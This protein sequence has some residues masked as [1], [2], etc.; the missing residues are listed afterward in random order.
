[1]KRYILCLLTAVIGLSA[2]SRSPSKSLC[3][4]PAYPLAVGDSKSSDITYS[5]NGLYMYDIIQDSLPHYEIG[6]IDIQ[7]VRYMEEGSGFYVKADS[8]HAHNVQFSYEVEDAPKGPIEFNETTGRFKY[9]P[10]AEDYNS[11]FVTFHA[12]NGVDN[13]S[14]RVRFNLMPQTIAEEFAFRTEGTMPDGQD[15]TLIAEDSTSTAILLNNTTRKGRK[16]S[17]SGKEVVFDDKVENKVFGLSG[18][19]DIC[20]LNIFA[21]RLVVRSAL[22]F[23]QTNVTIYAKELV[24]EDKGDA[25]ASINTSPL[26]LE[27]L[28]NGQGQDG[29]NAGN[30]TL[31]V[32]DFKANPA[33][34]FIMN[35][36]KG[37]SANRNGTPANGGN[38]GTLTSNIDL[39]NYCDFVRGSGGVRFDVAD[40][41]STA[42]GAVIAA[43]AMG[44]DGH[45]ELVD[46]PYAYLHPYYISAVI[47]QV[48]DAFVNNY[49]Q[50][51]LQTCSEYKALIDEYMSSEAW[52]QCEAE[53]EVELKNDLTEIEGLLFKLDQGLDYFGNPIGWTPLLS[54]EVMLTNFDNE[55]ERA[56]PTLYMY[57]WLSRVDQTL[58][59]KVLANQQFA[60]IAEQEIQS[61]QEFINN[62]VLKI[63]VI[64]DELKEVESM[65]EIVNQKIGEIENHL[66][67]KARHN[68][69][70]KNRIKK[71]ASICKSIASAVS[72]CG[73]WGAAIGTALNV[74]SN[75]AF[76]SGKL[77]EYT[78]LDTS[79][80]NDLYNEASNIFGNAG[81]VSIDSLKKIITDIPWKDIGDDPNMLKTQFDRFSNAAGPLISNITSLSGTLSKSSTPDDEVQRE[82]KRL[83]SESTEWNALNTEMDKLNAK[84][85]K[86][87]SD[88]VLTFKDI[89]TTLS[90]VGGDIISLDVFRRKVFD[91]NSKRDLNAMQYLERMEQK[92]KFR[93]LKYHY[94]LRKAYEY[95]L[96][97]PYQGE[98][99]LVGMFER[100][101]RLGSTFGDIVNPDAYSTLAS[102][103]K[104]VISEM[105]EEIIN[106]YSVNY[107]EQSAP[108]TIVIP[109]EQLNV[110]NDGENLVLNLHDM[111]VFAPDEENVRIVDLAIQHI[112]THIDGNVGYSGY[113]DLNMTHEGISKFR[114]DGR[115]YWFDHR[116]QSTTSPHT[117]GV[118]YDAV[119][120]ESTMIQPSAATSSLLAAILKTNTANNLM[121]FS[122]PSAW[123]DI[124]M[125]KKV[126]TS[127]G[128]DVVVDSLVLRLQY[129][130]TRRPNNLRNIDIATSNQLMPHI[131]CSET[132]IN[133]R[134]NGNGSFY[135]SYNLS[136][137]PITF[138]AIE[139][140]GTYC[141]ANWTDRSGKIVSDEPT[142]TVSREIDQ[143]YTANYVR[144]LPIL[145]VPDTIWVGHD[146]GTQVVDVRN[147]GKGNIE[148]EWYVSDEK[149]SW[150]HLE[151]GA[152]GI[153][154]GIFSFKY[155]L[156]ENRIQRKD[157]IVIYA[158]ETEIGSKTIYISQVDDPTIGIS[159]IVATDGE[160]VIS[161]NPTSNN[162]TVRGEALVSVEI[163][164]AT[165]Q[166]IASYSANGRTH[167]T[168]NIGQY[169][170]GVYVFAV[171]SKNGM[172][173]KKVLKN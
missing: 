4:R 106:D 137:Q 72:V 159:P 88:L 52:S 14:E 78:G 169:P 30:I 104:D 148:M 167:I 5:S 131:S 84:K 154:N 157:S 111:G 40:D 93:L 140:Y 153:D 38:G 112:E 81:T 89:N 155:E 41:G 42:A 3:L 69:K 59:N 11:F 142:L 90:D 100:F 56:I 24:F 12:T 43:G 114:K 80:I 138:T 120:K 33:K 132:D 71:A 101:E 58:Q 21:E 26:P 13:L 55:V 50:Y 6:H 107:P 171:L 161:P 172:V 54:F 98:F 46:K 94:Y 8:L 136:S 92:A 39:S 53:D 127:G 37:Q 9:F 168:T 135:R 76:A 96:L 25:I 144:L 2:F 86:L 16:F 125:S 49:M 29:G 133:G 34:R 146:G 173:T 19:D 28:E 82:F 143:F 117:W 7:T 113:M 57:Y 149:S 36:A 65:I 160:I 164:S 79:P 20:E 64:E 10:A 147:T 129:D 95:R 150:V 116:S 61:S 119:S 103:F 110:I 1:M 75:V 85:Q 47:R 105:A 74:A 51:A 87:W 156:N 67:S 73:P 68:V 62:L 128:A 27:I 91:G 151:D 139:Q 121:L 170:N 70:K 99:N 60:A 134:S 126:H 48:N 45:F 124:T 66:M 44:S 31:F 102:V 108:I 35:G 22:T 118:R 32:R 15:Y 83:C 23:P 162:V 152:E 122:R 130:F 158:P 165:G 166:K 109:R 145:S 97:K 163:Y 17:I 141:F 18:R 77:Q 123:G 115:L 63:P